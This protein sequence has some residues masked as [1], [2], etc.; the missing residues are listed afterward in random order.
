MAT[1]IIDSQIYRSAFAPLQVARREWL[2]ATE[3]VIRLQIAIAE[4]V[5]SHSFASMYAMFDNRT[6]SEYFR[7]QG[8]LTTDLYRKTSD[9]VQAFI[10]ETSTGLERSGESMADAANEFGEAAKRAGKEAQQ[11]VEKSA[12][13]VKE[14]AKQAS[15]QH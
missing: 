7:K 8:E 1:S 4:D 6:P 5:V 11:V 2:K 14:A 12:R 10:E 9:R 13:N 15:G 3:R